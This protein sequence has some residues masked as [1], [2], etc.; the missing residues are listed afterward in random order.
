VHGHLNIFFCYALGGKYA[1]YKKRHVLCIRKTELKG[2]AAPF[3]LPETIGKKQ[4]NHHFIERRP[5][6]QVIAE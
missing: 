2:N 3:W 5:K 6:F 1:E 4:V